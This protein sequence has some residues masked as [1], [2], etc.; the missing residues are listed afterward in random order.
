MTNP[1]DDIF[2]DS[3]KEK[4]QTQSKT[5]KREF[6]ELEFNNESDFVMDGKESLDE[7]L[8]NIE[9]FKIQAEPFSQLLTTTRAVDHKITKNIFSLFIIATDPHNQ[10]NLRK[11]RKY[12]S[13]LKKKFNAI[14]LPMK[15]LAKIHLQTVLQFNNDVGD[16]YYSV[17]KTDRK[18][19]LDRLEVMESINRQR[20]ILGNAA[21]DLEI[22]KDGIEKTEDRIRRYINVGG[23]DNISRAEY[24][25]ITEKTS[26]LVTG[27][28]YK[29]NYTIFNI[30][31]FDKAVITLGIYMKKTTSQYLENLKKAFE[32]GIGY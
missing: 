2:E 6:S 7:V 17:E 5:N 3:E 4:K 21:S 25:V 20:R 10:K 30:N 16:D 11:E 29:F 27:Q 8:D 1:Y 12:H 9:L 22:L 24:E 15:K 32:V 26:T 14:I 18:V 13:L 23:V 31:R 28:D 19:K